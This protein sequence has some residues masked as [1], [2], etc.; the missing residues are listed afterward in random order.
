[1]VSG[2]PVQNLSQGLAWVCELA[3]ACGQAK[4]PACLSVSEWAGAPVAWE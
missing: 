2:L 3:S 4:E 1:M